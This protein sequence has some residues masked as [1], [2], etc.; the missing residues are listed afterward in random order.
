LIDKQK[1][2]LLQ[3]ILK[4]KKISIIKVAIFFVLIVVISSCSSDDSSDSN[5]TT[6][7]NYLPLA[8]NNSWKYFNQNQSLINEVKIIGTDQFQ[9]TTYYEFNDDSQA[10]FNARQ[11]FGKKGATYLLKTGDTSINESGITVNIKSYELPILKDDYDLDVFWTGRVSPKVTYSGSG[12]SGTLPF[13][14]DYSGVNYFKGELT[15]NGTTYPNVIKTRLSITINANDQI[16]NAS[17]EYW[18]AENIGVIKI[19][20]TSNNTI[21]EKDIDSYILN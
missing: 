8:T 5:G 20:T 3:K 14:I 9:G 15:L 2:L 18:Y 6:T 11:W 13:K 7:G 1:S 19:I 12:Q 17:E 21:E 16:T 10:D 4:M